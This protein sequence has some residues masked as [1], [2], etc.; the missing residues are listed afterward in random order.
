MANYAMLGK[1]H[2][3]APGYAKDAMRFGGTCKAV[4]DPDAKVAED[5]AKE[6]GCDA[7]SDL[8]AL[9][10]REDIDCVLVGTPTS[11]HYEV[12]MKVIAAGKHIFTEKTLA[13]TVKECEEIAAAIR[14]KGLLFEISYPQRTWPSV[15]Y[16]KQII[17]SGVLGKISIGRF[18]NAHGGASANWLPAYWYEK[19]DACG[20]AMMDLGCHPMYI[21]AYLFGMPKRISSMYNI[22][23]G[24]GVDDNAVNTI[25]FENKAIAIVETS[26][27]TP[28]SPWAFEIYGTKGYLCATDHQVRITTPET[29]KYTN[30]MVPVKNLPKPLDN[31]LENF[32]KAV[33]GKAEI[34]FGLDDAIDLARLLE[35]AYISDEKGITV[36]I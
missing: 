21:A 23:T 11:M 4:W 6:L 33:D 16:A 14:E 13:P 29:R 30:D 5:W 25:E 8:D 24:H 36:N 12:I 35:N 7:Y 31:P 19:K 17:E 20:G 27:V 26:F 3:H 10:A 22:L 18:R 32:I 9:L 2:V 28:I 15:L 34:Q 1:W